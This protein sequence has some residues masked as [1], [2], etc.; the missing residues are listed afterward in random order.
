M[1]KRFSKLFILF[2]VSLLLS[3]LVGSQQLIALPSQL[4]QA[5]QDYEQGQYQN[6]IAILESYLKTSPSERLE[7]YYPL[8]E[9]YAA[10][11][12]VGEAIGVW[13]QG[14]LAY[15]HLNNSSPELAELLIKQS[16]AY[17]NLGQNQKAISLLEEATKISKSFP[18]LYSLALGTQG[19]AYLQQGKFERA[20][21]SYRASLDLSQP[22]GNSPLILTALNNLT[23]ASLKLSQ[24]YE[25]DAEFALQEKDLKES[26]RFKS[27]A[28]QSHLEAS[29]YAIWAVEASQEINNLSKVKAYLNAI[30][31]VRAPDSSV[32]RQRA[33]NLLQKQPDSRTKVFLLINLA[34][35]DRDRRIGLLENAVE[36]ASRIKDDR[37]LSFALGALGE[38]NERVGDYDSSLRY[39]E[40]AIEAAKQVFAYDSLY[41][42]WWLSGR[43]YRSAGKETEAIAAYRR[44]I[45]SLQEIRSDIASASQEYQ[46]NFR[47]EVEPVYREF[48]ELLLSQDRSERWQ[49]ALDTFDLLQLAELETYFGD[50]C[51]PVKQSL[52]PSKFLAQ[53]QSLAISTIILPQKTYLIVLRPDDKI[54]RYPI[55]IRA[56]QLT[57][58]I[59]SWRDELENGYNRQFLKPS[60]SLYDLLVRPLEQDFVEVNPKT[61][62]FIGDRNLRNVPMAALYDGKHYLIEKYSIAVSLGLKL[63]SQENR[64]EEQKAL[65]F[66][67]TKAI[68]PFN[69]DL[70][71]VALETEEIQAIMGGDRFLDRDFTWEN[72][73]RHFLTNSERASIVHLATHGRFSGS[74]ERSFIQTFDRLVSL[75][76]LESLFNQNEKP[77]DLLT[78]SLCQTAAGNERSVF[79]LAGIAI[80][81]GIPSIIGALW[82]ANDEASAD[83]MTRFYSNLKQ[84]LSKAEALQKVQ[85]EQISQIGH[86][87]DWANYI[88]VGNWL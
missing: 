40:Q 79:G 44:E 66:G 51:T 39:A 64:G 73:R 41:R 8:G 61:L 12:K 53:T 69:S 58:Q 36:S 48:I 56:E 22:L 24:K 32:Y 55:A 81:S 13:E 17:I 76:D 35:L 72:F 5:Q 28:S 47:S 50:V 45:A 10:V 54:H 49:E 82:F 70:P 68:S 71:N 23:S 16:Q 88:L 42:W 26:D 84:G 87:T 31:L 38:A 75:S 86:P 85:I 43:I 27:L 33:S 37:A 11:G 25:R 21:E 6:A 3:L 57:G 20:I 1:L 77:I 59:Q 15:R 63:I 52:E 9:A 7:I 29:K 34:D 78:L 2:L 19:N 83:F 14:V 4:K 30:S 65:T 62:V 80:R 67:S 74:T 18:A 46:F 60:Q